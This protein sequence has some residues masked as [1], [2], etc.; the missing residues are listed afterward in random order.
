VRSLVA[1]GRELVEAQCTVE[2]PGADV[3]LVLLRRRLVGQ[4]VDPT[5]A[6]ALVRATAAR[7]EAAGT[8]DAALAGTLDMAAPPERRV[9]LLVGAPGDGKTTTAVKLA[10]RARREGRRVALVGADTY[11][12]GAAAELETYGRAIGVP[13]VRVARAGDLTRVLASLTEADLVLIDTAGA[14]PGQE[15]TLDELRKLTEAAG[16]EA[17]CVLVA[18]AATAA[19][20]A[21]RAWEAFAPLGPEACV[22][23]KCDVAAGAAVLGLTWRRGL[24][25]SHVAAG[26]NVSG[27]LEI[28][29]PD[30][31]ARCLLAA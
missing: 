30:R 19:H 28:A 15:T 4:G 8:V 13:V 29:T 11:R 25:V 22:L 18:S 27:D 31:L 21:G 26:R 17:G 9:R 7:L 12:V 14:A 5:I 10:V 20:V 24:P 16:P 1:T 3:D 2:V 23:T 6:T